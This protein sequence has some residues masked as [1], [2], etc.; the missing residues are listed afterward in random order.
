MQ[1]IRT[2]VRLETRVG[3]LGVVE[4]K[5]SLFRRSDIDWYWPIGPFAPSTPPWAALGDEVAA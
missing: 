3:V 2:G 1:G 4:H 5:A